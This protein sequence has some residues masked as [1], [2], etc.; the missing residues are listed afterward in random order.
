MMLFSLKE[1]LNNKLGEQ[2]KFTKADYEDSSC[3]SSSQ[4]SSEEEIE[5]PIIPPTTQSSP[6]PGFIKSQLQSIEEEM[7]ELVVHL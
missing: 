2:L 7:S 1:D 4:E 5:T 3:K 6:R